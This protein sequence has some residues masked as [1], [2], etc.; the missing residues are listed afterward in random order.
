MT[1]AARCLLVGALV[2]AASTTA[3]ARP[4]VFRGGTDTVQL[5]VTVTD[6][7][8]HFVTG[9]H[10]EDFQIF[11]DGVP[12]DISLFSGERQPIA[13]SML[14][15]SSTSMESKLAIAKEAAVGFARRLGARDLAEVIDFDNHESILQ[16]FTHDVPALEAAIHK[17]EAGGSTALYDAIYIALR[18]LARA[19]GVASDDIRRQAIIVLSDGEDTASL[20]TYDDV[21]DEAK[22]AEALIYGIALHA[23]EDGPHK[24]F[25]QGDFVMRTLAQ[26]TGGWAFFVE[27]LAQ[28]SGVYQKVADELSNQYVLGFVSKNRK[29][30]G[31]WR[32]IAVRVNRPDTAARTRSGYFAPAAD[33]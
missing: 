24:G 32:R 8:Q 26:E 14:I 1:G 17:T 19:P 25:S 28:L 23:K 20:K 13:L 21:L 10:R 31:T 16:G 11:E 30:D 33:R 22:R 18:D 27:D 15:D 7:A 29:H 6:A 5:S 4:Q 12:Q 2:A 3:R 9:L